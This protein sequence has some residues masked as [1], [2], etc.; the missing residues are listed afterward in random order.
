M[1][2]GYGYEGSGKMSKMSKKKNGLMESTYM[3]PSKAKKKLS[4]KAKKK[5]FGY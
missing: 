2:K 4:Q 5:S 3:N 1:P